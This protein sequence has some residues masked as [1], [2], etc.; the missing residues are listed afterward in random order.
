MIIGID[1]SR[2]N[3]AEKTGTE[4]YS[5]HIIRHLISRLSGHTVR[6]YVREPLGEGLRSL[7]PN[8]EEHVLAWAPGFL[9]SHLRLSWEMFWHRPDVL[10]V[11]ADT[12]PLIH[13]QRTIA[14]IHDIAFERWPELYSQK[15]V[16]RKMRW[17]RPLVN[18]GI[19]LVTLG[20]FGASELD[21]HR[22]S[23]RH[24]L[25]ACQTI[26]AVSEFT[27]QELVDVLLADPRKIVV[28]H[29]GVVQPNE[30]DQEIS[31]A[32]PALFAK[33]GLHQPYF[34]YNGR[35]ERKKNIVPLLKGFDRFFRQDTSTDL[36]LV[37]SKG[38][39]WEEAQAWLSEHPESAAH[40][41]ILPWQPTADLWK[42]MRQ[43]VGYVFVSAYEGFGR[44]PLEAL[45]C[46]TASIVAN[47][48]SLPEVLGD[49]ALY[50][51]PN[52]P[53]ELAEAMATIRQNPEHR[54][55]LI[56]RGQAQVKKFTW[57]KVA[58]KTASVL[59]QS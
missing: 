52:D 25:R 9:W 42:L 33:L 43:A 11:P 18:L 34:L 31:A 38:T 22:W 59:L 47:H 13:P 12:V 36:V 50:V 45:S 29:Q 23:V 7:G 26:I 4:W 21:Y 5:W 20:K 57:D 40:V 49:A 28:T 10:F 8:V 41:Y 2:A 16:Q 17:L 1:A 35:L 6:L 55:G 56:D 14:T 19:R 27:K 54:Q 58:D 46:G 39:G 15:S 3:V 44:P 24:A 51:E 37:G 32:D 48:S 30:V 53:V